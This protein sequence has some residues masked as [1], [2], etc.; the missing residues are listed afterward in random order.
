MKKTYALLA[1]LVVVFIANAQQEQDK[2]VPFP[3]KLNLT[4][5]TLTFKTIDAPNKTFG[6]DIYDNDKLMIHQPSIPAIPGKDGF[7][8]R[9]SAE[10]IAQLVIS[11]IKKG[12]MPPTVSPE[13]L[14]NLQVLK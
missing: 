13:E 4:Y 14:K 10:K 11:K 8:T 1:F 7:K 5:S 12:E 3:D 6:Y 9:A 2:S